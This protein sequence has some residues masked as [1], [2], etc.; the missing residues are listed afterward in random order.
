MST[1]LLNPYD[2]C[3]D[4][5]S[6]DD[7][8]LYHD[9]C[10]GLTDNKFDGK[11]ENFNDFIKLIENEFQKT[12]VMEA[13]EI[14]TE[15]DISASDTEDQKMPTAEGT[16]NS[17]RSKQLTKEEVL[18][19]VELVWPPTPHGTA[20]PRYFKRFTSSPTTTDELEKER[21]QRRLKHVMMGWKLWNSLTAS[22]QIEL[23][24]GKPE[25]ERNNECDGPLLWDYIRRRVNPSTTV[26]ASKLK[27]MIET[28]T[29]SNFN[30]DVLKYDT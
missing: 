14:T 21:N 30:H 28:K 9:A 11:K 29:L 24:G 5:S 20:T 26:G 12:R 1:F 27:E 16:I 17:F 7:R 23:M 22:F 8:K 4:L 3:L 25:F 13:L 19:H 18:A 6:K 10:K 15:W 2:A